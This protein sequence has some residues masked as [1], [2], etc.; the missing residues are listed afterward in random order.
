MKRYIIHDTL[1]AL[2]R[3]L[4]TD[5]SYFLGLTQ[6]ANINKSVAQEPIRAG[7][8]NKVVGMIQSDDGMTF[9]V[10][11]GMHY[12]DVYEIQTGNTFTNGSATIQKVVENANGTFTATDE[13]VTGSILDLNAD[14]L[15]KNYE[16][17]LKG[18]AFCPETNRV[19][20]DIFWIFHKALPDGNLAETF[21]AG[22]NKTTELN[23]TAQIPLGDSSY[24]KYVVVPRV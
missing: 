14:N 11:V 16:V 7:L 3:D 23:F 5:E 22:S 1:E 9:G 6:S 13:E 20:A 24:G 10:T 15:P 8:H 19:A 2:V 21:Q 12:N 18:I 4:D 17:Q